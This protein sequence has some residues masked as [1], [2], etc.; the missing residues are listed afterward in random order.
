MVGVR[1]G[2]RDD[3][4]AAWDGVAAAA[5]VTEGEVALVPGD[6]DYR[7]ARPGLRAGNS[8]HRRVQEG[9][10]GGDE[11]LL[12]G[13]AAGIG[14]W[15]ATSMHVIALVRADPHVIRHGVRGQVG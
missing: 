5:Y 12:V 11:L 15:R 2:Q 7:V 9:V 4:A 10:A 14:G 13:E 3:M 6:E 1:D 8:V